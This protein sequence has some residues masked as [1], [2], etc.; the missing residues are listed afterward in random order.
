MYLIQCIVPD[1]SHSDLLNSLFIH[2]LINNLTNSRKQAS[3]QLKIT[4]T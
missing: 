3:F 2:P 1:H 4:D